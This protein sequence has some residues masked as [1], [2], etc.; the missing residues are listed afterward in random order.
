MAQIFIS[1]KRVDK[2]KSFKI[3]TIKFDYLIYCPREEAQISIKPY[4]MQS[5]ATPLKDMIEHYH[6]EKL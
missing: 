3:T 4:N 6:F 5:Y 1:H 2:E